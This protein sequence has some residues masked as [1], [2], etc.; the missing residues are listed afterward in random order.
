[1]KLIMFFRPGVGP[2]DH[3]WSADGT[4]GVPFVLVWVF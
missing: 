2:C 3:V 4:E 1:M